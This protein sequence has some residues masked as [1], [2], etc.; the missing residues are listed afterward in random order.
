MNC[1]ELVKV[2]TKLLFLQ[3]SSLVCVSPVL[4]PGSNGPANVVK[5]DTPRPFTGTERK[6]RQNFAEGFFNMVCSKVRVHG[7][8]FLQSSYQLSSYSNVYEKKI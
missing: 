1:V 5:W 6:S 8:I 3:I 4:A 7:Y 2:T